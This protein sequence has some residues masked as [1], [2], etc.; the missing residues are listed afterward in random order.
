MEEIERSGASVEEAVEAALAELGLSEQEAEVEVIQEPRSGFL[1]INSAPAI[2]RVRPAVPRATQDAVSPGELEEQGEVAAEFLEGLLDVVGFDADVEL[3]IED[4]TV[5]LEMWGPE[6]EEGGMGVLIGRHGHTLDALQDLVRAA[7][8]HQTESRCRVV[9][10]VED[11]RKRRRSQIA[12]RAREAARRVQ[13]T[14]RPEALEP[15]T[16]FER[17]VV[18]DTVAEEDGLATASEGEEPNRRVVITPRGRG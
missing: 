17:K 16:A 7:V 15:M 9:V 1:G 13:K 12:R 18:H 11:Y 6:D 5:Y 10:D 4:G 8:Q 2:V 14:G 3:A